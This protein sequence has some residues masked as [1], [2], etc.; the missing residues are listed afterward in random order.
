MMTPEQQTS[1][2]SLVGRALT[3]EEVTEIDQYLPQRN[4]VAIADILSRNRVTAVTRLIGI[5]IIMNV[6][7]PVEGAAA[8]DV[9]ES[10]KP[11]NSAVKWALHLLE[12]GQLDIGLPAT[13]MQIDA[14]VGTVFT[15][16]QASTLKAIAEEADPFNYNSI[17]NA[18]NIAEG[19]LTL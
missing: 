9:L 14:L 3:A 12:S 10:M 8:L 17:S 4:D 19:R 6:L 13:R 15:A 11:S 18:L 2:E 7:G 1:L 16:E 5:G